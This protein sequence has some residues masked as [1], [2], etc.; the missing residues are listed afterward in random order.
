ML[1][2]CTQPVDTNEN[3][4]RT[5]QRQLRDDQCDGQRVCQGFGQSDARE[6]FA[7]T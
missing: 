4:T 6:K 2:D 7:E 3:A 5:R 1:R